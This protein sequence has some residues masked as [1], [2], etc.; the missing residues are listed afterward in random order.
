MGRRLALIACAVLFAAP[1]AAQADD[2]PFIDW[3]PLLPGFP[4]D[5]KPSVERDCLD[6]SGACIERTLGEMYRRFDR[7]YASCDHNSVFGL[8]YI[9]VTESVRQWVLDGRYEEPAF[10]N[11]EDAVFARMY[12]DAYDAWARGD[13]ARVPVAWQEV[14]DS[15]R[16]RTVSGIG[17]LLMSMNAHINRDFPFMLA[18][19]GLAMPDGRS[20]KPDHDLGNQLLNPLYDDIFEEIAT[21]WD[22]T[23]MNYDV[24][25]GEA[26]NTATFQILQAWREQV[27][28][29]AELLVAAPTPEARQAIADYIEDYAVGVGRAIKANTTIPDSSARDEHCSAYRQKHAE[30]GALARPVIRKRG[31]KLRKRK[32]GLRLACPA[33]TRTCDGT[34]VLRRR[35]RRP[36]MAAVQFPAISPGR[37]VVLKL[38]VGRRARR[39]LRVRGRIR[40]RALVSTTTPWGAPVFASRHARLKR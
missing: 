28:R 24:P 4:M 15:G 3:T 7:L 18:N 23:I 8:V 36:R 17:N 21:R 2:A 35:A 1:A 22:P 25:G 34:L 13:R 11:H 31:L 39:A 29:H 9:R 12:F 6:G 20:R 40:V 14:F 5:Y 19:L 26:D 37:S 30:R 32:V 16:D 33:G 27:W 38:P 10:L